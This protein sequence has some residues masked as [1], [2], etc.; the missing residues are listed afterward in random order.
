[1]LIADAGLRIGHD[2]QDRLLQQPNDD[3]AGG[4]GDLRR[5]DVGQDIVAELRQ[6]LAGIRHRSRSLPCPGE[7]EGLCRRVRRRE[8]HRQADHVGLLP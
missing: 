5:V 3:V 1:M 4:I 7:I 2:A 6:R 8:R